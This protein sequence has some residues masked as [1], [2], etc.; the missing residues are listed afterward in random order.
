MAT[1][2]AACLFLTGLIVS[3]S[4][5]DTREA[6]AF[7]KDIHFDVTFALALASAWR[8]NEALVIASADQGIDE[9]AET[10]PSFNVSDKV[11]ETWLSGV[12]YAFHCFSPQ[13]DARGERHPSVLH[14]ALAKL[15]NKAESAI[16]QA[17][18]P[19]AK[20]S[21]ETRALLAIGVYL[22]CQQDSWAHSGFGGTRVGHA[23]ENINPLGQSPDH[24]AVDAGIT[25]RA[26]GESVEH[27]SAF[28]QRW[29]APPGAS[30]DPD[31]LTLLV[32]SIT[33]QASLGMSGPEREECN[34]SRAQHWVYVVF[35]R[36]GRLHDPDAI[37][38]HEQKDLVV[39]LARSRPRILQGGMMVQ[40]RQL[41][42]SRS[43]EAV[44]AHSF[45]DVAADLKESPDEC[46][47]VVCGPLKFY[48]IPFPTPKYPILGID[49]SLAPGTIDD[50][51]GEYQPLN[52]TR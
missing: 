8:W 20:K 17:K 5:V 38:D 45:L 23:L 40:A 16:D 7:E 10:R 47:D 21:D 24:P 12:D 49:V 51:T 26:V 41:M 14:G 3:C 25:E 44:F 27:L 11:P 42:V 34:A 1:T 52:S 18:A 2:T 19:G 35:T 50:T 36:T 9:N 15:K 31:D 6:T 48:H 28:L 39:I 43:C 22:H 32:H 37:G 46:T 29:K 13:K 33:D 30:I 4:I